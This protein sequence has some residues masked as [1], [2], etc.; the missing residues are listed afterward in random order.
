MNHE[1]PFCRTNFVMDTVGH[2][3]T[4]GGA[5]DREQGGKV[6]VTPLFFSLAGSINLSY[7]TQ[8]TS[9][10]PLHSIRNLPDSNR[11][12][13]CRKLVSGKVATPTI[14]TLLIP[15][16]PLII[17]SHSRMFIT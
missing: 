16:T 2:S 6:M 15:T 4:A 14:T 7:R 1:L 9:S 11:K 8:E 13:K 3:R 10:D 17:V 5:D 12:Q